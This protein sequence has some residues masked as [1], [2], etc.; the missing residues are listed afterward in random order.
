L[1][2]RQQDAHHVDKEAFGILAQVFRRC[3]LNFKLEGLVSLKGFEKFLHYFKYYTDQAFRMAEEYGNEPSC[4]EAMDV[5]C[6]TWS[7]LSKLIY[8]DIPLDPRC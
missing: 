3:L 4:K 8:L 1:S 5:V 2:S 6:E 7:L